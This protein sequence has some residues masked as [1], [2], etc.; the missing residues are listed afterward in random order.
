M[1][2]E[3]STEGTVERWLCG[4]CA[5]L[6]GLSPNSP[7][8]PDSKAQQPVDPAP[9]PMASTGSLTAQSFMRRLEEG[10]AAR[11]NRCPSCGS[12]YADIRRK[13]LLGCAI[14]Y[15]TFEL[16]VAELLRRIH[17]EGRHR[18]KTPTLI[19][20]SGGAVEATDPSKVLS[21]LKGELR[22]AVGREAYEQAARLR[23]RIR[24]LE[25]E[26]KANKE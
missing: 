5:D 22:E 26:L 11:R 20:E 4:P 2:R 6:S 19:E 12:A 3:I 8:S 25:T 10:R 16:E 9:T 13:G 23:D 18:G 14:C 21:L 15:D 7:D 17:S 1:V 24:E